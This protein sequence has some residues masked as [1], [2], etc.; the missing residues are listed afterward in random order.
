[1]ANLTQTVP[2]SFDDLFSEARSM[3]QQAGFDVSDGSNTSQLAAIQAYLISALNTNTALNINETLLP[4]ATKRKNILQDARVLGYEAQHITS[5]Q[6]KLKIRLSYDLIGYGKIEIPRYSQFKSSNNTYVFFSNDSDIVRSSFNG[7]VVNTGKFKIGDTEFSPKELTFEYSEKTGYIKTA[8][9]SDGRYIDNLKELHKL[10]EKNRDIEISVKE[11]ELID[12]SIDPSSLQI[13]IGSVSVNNETYTRNYIDIPYTNI[14]NDG[15]NVYVSFY[16]AFG[17]YQEKIPYL[18][19][20][21]YFFEKD[22]NNTAIKHRFIRLDDIEMGTPR[23]YFKY[24]G[25]GEGVP[26]G[27]VVQIS[28][29]KSNGPNG[30]MNNLLSTKNIFSKP[31]YNFM[32]NREQTEAEKILEDLT[33]S[34]TEELNVFSGISLPDVSSGSGTSDF[35][36]S[37]IFNDASIIGCDLIVTG[38]SEESSQSIISNAPKVYNSANRLVTNLDFKYACNR[39]SYVYDSAVWGGEEEFPKSPGHIWF[40]FVPEKISER[41]FTS[42]YNNTEFQR[43]NSELVY[44]YAEGESVYQHQMRQEFYNKNYILN[45]EIKSYSTFINE[46]GTVTRTYSGVWGDLLNKFIPSLTFHHRHPIYL[47]FNYT[48]NILKY[49]LKDTTKNVHKVLFD[50]L[51]NCFYGNDSLNLENFDIEYFHT[52]IVKRIDFLISDLCGFTSNLETQLMLNEK[53][54]CTENW[55]SEYKDIYIPLA[56]PFEKYFTDDGYLDTSRLPNIDTEK[57]INFTYDLIRDP[58]GI[59]GEENTS[60]NSA[61][62]EYDGQYISKYS[63]EKSLRFSLVTGDLF[64]D[65]SKINQNTQQNKQLSLENSDNIDYTDINK[66]IFVAPVKIKMKYRYL[67]TQDFI[68]SFSDDVVKIKLGFKLAPDNTKDESFN[69]IQCTLYKDNDSGI[70]ILSKEQLKPFIQYNFSD[71]TLLNLSVYNIDQ[72][73]FKPGEIL[74]VEFERTCGYYYLFNTFKKEILV[75]LFVNGEY[76]GFKDAANGMR[77]NKY[78]DTYLEE[79]SSVWNINENKIYDDTNFVDITYSTPKAYLYTS[80]K[81][82]ITADE[83]ETA[84]EAENIS[85]NISTGT[86]ID[87]YS[88]ANGK[89]NTRFITTEG[90]LIDVLKDTLDMDYYTGEMV[91]NYSE[92]MYLYTPLTVDLFRQN[93]YLNLKYP[94]LNFKVLRNIV[95]R[96]N[97]VK[98][99]NAIDLY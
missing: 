89:A 19:T 30:E 33:D 43:N 85:S 31:D 83:N 38:K 45:T 99:K 48:F 78:Y 56:V 73:K 96:L 12:Y 6:Y 64:V 67:V 74:E 69:N 21:D 62:S 7:I 39:S 63:K 20:N 71:R 70:E 50:A 36:I 68:N 47:N 66:K 95:P 40:S 86:I 24:A 42:D 79:L 16:D 9:T 29:L 93:V 72:S 52:N 57:F 13:T 84:M 4:Y 10:F 81:K 55:K 41:G 49:N 60:E 44:N 90:Y 34:E 46:N 8:K 23:I 58:L 76:E 37:N 59:Y 26:F 61:Y 97:N 18:R 32:Y 27:S 94:S 17:N 87:N 25:L 82:F 91:R 75:H 15:I 54:L 98:F 2:F 11:G 51:D 1:M 3:F 35:Y 80:D 28:I 5:F 14:E 92:K 22:P 53:S 77:S 88:P 65:W